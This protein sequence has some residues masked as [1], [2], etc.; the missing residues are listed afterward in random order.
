[1]TSTTE[2][3]STSTS[4]VPKVATEEYVETLLA[5]ALMKFNQGREAELSTITNLA[6]RLGNMESTVSRIVQLLETAQQHTEA[7]AALAQSHRFDPTQIANSLDAILTAYSKVK[8]V[9]G[10]EPTEIDRWGAAFAEIAKREAL[11]AMK[12]NV[13][14]GLRRGIVDPGTIESIVG[15]KLDRHVGGGGSH[16]P[17]L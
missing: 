14:K 9:S 15:E 8:Q 4:D 5:A 10:G 3:W 6:D 16:E 2:E 13:R 12:L 17:V 7:P 1:M 11:S